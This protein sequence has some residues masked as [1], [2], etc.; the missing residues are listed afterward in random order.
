MQIFDFL[1]EF[2]HSA[3][4]F[5][6]FFDKCISSDSLIQCL[7]CVGF[8]FNFLEKKSQYV[9]NYS[10]AKLFIDKG[11]KSEWTAWYANWTTST[12]SVKEAK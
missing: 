6:L 7:I 11:L 1:M 9:R 10:D 2:F 12:P 4:F 3:L 5:D 8:Y